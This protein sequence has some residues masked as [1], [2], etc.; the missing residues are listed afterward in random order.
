MLLFIKIQI[1]C[2]NLGST[3]FRETKYK[4]VPLISAI[5]P[6]YNEESTI[7][8][9]L[10]CL[11]AAAIP[12]ME[13][14][15]VDDASTDNTAKICLEYPVT[16]LRQSENHGPA[17]SRNYGVAHST[18]EWLLFLDADIS[19]DSDL[20]RRMAT[21]LENNPSHAGV[22]SLTS[23][24]PLNAGYAPRFVALQ[25]YLRYSGI[26]DN[27]YRSWSYITTRFGIL[28]RSVF[29]EI[30]GFNESLGFAAF[31]DLEFCGRMADSH[32]LVLDKSFLIRHHFPET[33]WKMMR[34]L[35]LIARGVMSFSAPVRKKI[36]GPFVKDRNARV[37][38]GISWLFGCAGFAA[39]PFWLGFAACQLGA[40]FCIPWLPLGFYRSSGFLFAASGWLTY[41]ATMLPFLTGATLGLIDRLTMR[42]RAGE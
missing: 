12:G 17:Y 10:D 35:H 4:L 41:N 32:Q 38:L 36:S 33:I 2:I 39:Y 31:E 8:T 30:G 22:L 21:A 29:D 13:I 26:Y 42:R 1:L 9:T 20:I 34:R 11:F 23:P 16:L 15:V 25:D 3:N 7:R 37:L 27:G 18:G 40:A 6:V 28:K 14:I 24:E 5:L 19:F